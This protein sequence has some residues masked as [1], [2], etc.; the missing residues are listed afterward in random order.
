M[1]WADVGAVEA[2]TWD[3]LLDSPRRV[4]TFAILPNGDLAEFEKLV[5]LVELGDLTKLGEVAI[6]VEVS[7]LGEL[8]RLGEVAIRGEVA[9]IGELE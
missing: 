7:N 3:S 9:K 4:T 8:A 2:M 5:M 6:L 1:T